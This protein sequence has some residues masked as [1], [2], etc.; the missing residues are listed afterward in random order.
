MFQK[1]QPSISPLWYFT[2]PFIL[3]L[4]IYFGVSIMGH[5]AQ[6]ETTV[7]TK[8][9][10]DSDA[11]QD[12]VYYTEITQTATAANEV[13]CVDAREYHIVCYHANTGGT[14]I[15]VDIDRYWDDTTTY[16]GTV[17]SGEVNADITQAA[18]ESGCEAVIAPYYCYDVDSSTTGTL[19]LT[20]YLLRKSGIDTGF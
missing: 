8:S 5:A 1:R 16:D 15:N 2:L 14:G 4:A 6:T 11:K 19:S 20:W 17:N 13:D 12:I 9:L 3:A 18:D 10:V 7:A